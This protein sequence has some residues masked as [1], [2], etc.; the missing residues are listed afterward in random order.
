MQKIFSFTKKLNLLLIIVFFFLGGCKKDEATHSLISVT[1]IVVDKNNTKWVGTEDG[2][3]KGTDGNFS[4]QDISISKKVLSLLYEEKS[5][6]LWVGTDAGLLKATING[7]ELSGSVNIEPLKLSNPTIR[8]G[9]L[10]D[11][12]RKWFGT[13]IGITFNEGEKWKNDSFSINPIGMIYQ[14][15]ME[16]G[17]INS[18]ASWDGDYYF[19]TNGRSLWRG[20]RYN[21]NVDA[22]SG[23]TE[24]INPNDGKNITPIMNVVFVDSKEQIWMGGTNGIQV[25]KGHDQKDADNFTYYNSELADSIIHSIA[26]APNGKI[27]VGTEKGLSIFDG[28]NWTTHTEGLPD[29]FVTAIA[30]DKADGSAWVGTKKGIV[31][32]K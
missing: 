12:Q 24:W 29:L 27:W 3:F 6:T 22:I 10:D 32:V 21:D 18:I 14:D 11:N 31:N 1:S 16:F 23:A 4:F 26:E 17:R 28:T 2:L 30:F 15:N 9:Y 8:T 7:S 19:A 25:F 20:R 5:N 13:D